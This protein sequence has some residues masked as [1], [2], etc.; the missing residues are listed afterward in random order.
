MRLP[1]LDLDL[2]LPR[3]P[4]W[5]VSIAVLAV[6]ASFIPLVLIFDWRA[7]FHEEPRIHIFQDMDSQPRIHPQDYTLLFRDHRGMRP[8]VPGTVIHGRAEI[9]PHLTF[10]YRINPD[11]SP[12]LQS[13]TAGAATSDA[14]TSVAVPEAPSDP[15]A[16]PAPEPAP[17]AAAEPEPVW[18]TTLPEALTVDE[19]FLRIGQTRFMTFCFPCHGADGE[20]EGPIHRRAL[21]IKDPGWV[22]PAN[23]L[24]VNATDAGRV[25]NF[26]PELY[27]DGKLYNTI[28]HGKAN[29]AGYGSQISTRDRWAIVAYV[30]A[31]QESQSPGT[32]R[33]ARTPGTD[34]AVSSLATGD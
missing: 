15:N 22:A 20:G 3:P 14:A 2:R 18:Y 8:Q 31:L 24:L 30:R 6:V 32:L 29:M 5:M 12:V 13:P 26:G 11:G 28:T 19:R 21:L 23:L 9:D 4:F 27:P 16:A 33:T 17:P 10:G 34:A 25:Y 1:A 7:T